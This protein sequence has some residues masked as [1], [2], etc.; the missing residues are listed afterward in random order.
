MKKW[1][2][3]ISIIAVFGV[4]LTAEAMN[5]ATFVSVL[6]SIVCIVFIARSED[7]FEGLSEEIE[8][9]IDRLLNKITGNQDNTTP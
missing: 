1:I 7:Y 6:V 2:L 3:Y 8:K 4:A 9:D 5:I